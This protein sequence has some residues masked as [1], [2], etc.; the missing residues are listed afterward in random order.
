MKLYKNIG[1]AIFAST[2]ITSSIFAATQGAVSTETAEIYNENN[3]VLETVTYSTP[4]EIIDYE[5]EEDVY[6]LEDNLKIAS[7]SVYVS[8]FDATISGDNVN[9]RKNPSTVSEIIS[10]L[11]LNAE[12][13][14]LSKVENSDWYQIKY[15][16]LI[17]YVTSDY[18]SSKYKDLVS[19][20]NVS[21][22]EEV[23][24]N[25][26][27]ASIDSSDGLVLRSK[28]DATSEAITTIPGDEFA[29]I[30]SV[31]NEWFGVTYK[32]QSGFI[33][34]EFSTLHSGQMPDS[35]SNKADKIIDFAKQYVGK[36]YIWGG[37]TLSVGTDCSGFTSSV[38]KNFGISI[39]RTSSSQYSNGTRVS[40][41]ELKKGD[42]VFFDTSGGNNGSI[43]HVGMYVGNGQFIHSSTK[44]G[45]IVSDLNSGYYNNAY[46]GATRILS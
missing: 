23:P 46:V 21:Y 12:I 34:K 2:F 19:S 1:L 43:S 28:K 40:R 20:F 26:Y 14:I 27:Y 3:E 35:V 30:T 38:Y 18:V 8:T 22:I 37:T 39:N 16:D 33:S 24:A 15:E 9:F 17:G 32:D 45:V 10:T 7:S 13:I 6:V 25:T 31:S 44:R 42:L 4:V 36:P 41:G 11:P 5:P 29:K